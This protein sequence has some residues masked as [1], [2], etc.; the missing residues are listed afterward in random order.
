MI[1]ELFLS[2]I[3]GIV[4]PLVGISVGTTLAGWTVFRGVHPINAWL[5]A[6]LTVT[7]ILVLPGRDTSVIQICLGAAIGTTLV[8]WAM[9]T[10][11]WRSIRK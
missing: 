3:A 5:R 7:L 9:H 1:T 4:A 10:I 8:F 6:F 11:F 2:Q